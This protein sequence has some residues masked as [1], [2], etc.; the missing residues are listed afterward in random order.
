MTFASASSLVQGQGGIR[1]LEAW[2]VPIGVTPVV[3]VKDNDAVVCLVDAVS[4]PVL[5]APGPPQSFEWISEQHSNDSRPLGEWTGDELPRRK[6]RGRRKDIGE[7]ASGAG[8]QDDR[9][10]LAARIVSAHGARG[11]AVPP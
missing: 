11:L 4:N 5:A 10:W 7:R 9:V 1:I 3:D 8:S 2:S 6:G